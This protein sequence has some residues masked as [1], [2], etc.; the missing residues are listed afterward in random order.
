MHRFPILIN[1]IVVCISLMPGCAAAPVQEMSDARQAI[2]AAQEAGAENSAVNEYQEAQRLLELAEDQL[3]Q[4]H[5]R[6]AR[7]TA[8]SA[9]EMAIQSR[10]I[11]RESAATP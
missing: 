3:D 2:Q 6:K 5:Y 4:Q 8:L 10:E 1:V 7:R 11:A 9:K